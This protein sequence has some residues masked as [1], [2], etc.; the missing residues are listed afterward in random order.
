MASLGYLVPSQ[1]D[2]DYASVTLMPTHLKQKNEYLVEI[3]QFFIHQEP[4]SL[5]RQVYPNLHETTA[6]CVCVC[7]C[8]CERERERKRERKKARERE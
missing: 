4:S 1:H 6:M 5:L 2:D 3:I 7:V 8:V